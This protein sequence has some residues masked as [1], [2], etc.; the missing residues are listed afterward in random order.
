MVS[1]KIISRLH[2]ITQDF[3][4][5]THQRL[6]YEA[7][8]AGADLVQLRLKDRDF[9]EMLKIAKET[10][11][12]CADHGATLII[13]DHLDLAMEIDADGVHLGRK[14]TDHTIARSLLGDKKVIGGTAYN[15]SEALFLKSMGLV[16]YIGLGTFRKTRTKPEITE[17]MSIEKIASLV[18][19]LEQGKPAIPLIVIGGIEL[20]DIKP[21]MAKGVYGIAVASLVNRSGNKPKTI[22]EIWKRLG[23]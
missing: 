8:K 2:Y 5:K 6:A 3:P 22:S 23:G 16:D 17:F 9:A 10:K 14:D 7:C 1:N 13:N 18:C 21:L 12:I 4:D 11:E 19:Q 20:N 15:E